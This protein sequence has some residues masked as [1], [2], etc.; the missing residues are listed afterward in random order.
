MRI[1]RSWSKC[2]LPVLVLL[3][4]SVSAQYPLRLAFAQEP[5]TL[6]KKAEIFEYDLRTNFVFEGQMPP[7]RRPPT[8]EH[9][10]VS[11][12]MPDNAYMTG[13]YAG[14]LAM[15]Y[16]VT[17]D[18]NVRKEAGQAL[19]ALHL[20]STVSGKKGLLARAAVRKD[21]PFLDDGKW[22]DSP[23]G[24]YRWRADVSSDQMDGV[25]YGFCLL[26]DLVADD[27]EKKII[28]PDVAD[29]VGSI[30]DNKLRIVDIDGTPT[31]WG[32]Y[33]PEYVRIREHMN[34][35]LLLQHVKVAHHV[36]GD[37][38]FDKEYLRIANDLGYA[39]LAV[40][41]RGNANPLI[42]DAV[43]YSDDV[44]LYLAYYPL[45]VLEKDVAL[46]DKYLASLRRTW[47][48]D[49]KFPGIKPLGCTYYAF[50]VHAFL[51][52]ASG[53]EAGINTLKW[54]P[55]DMKWNRDVIL[56][57]EKQFK[58]TFDPTPKSSEP[59]KGEV[60]PIDR[61]PK[62]WSA[63]VWDPYVAGDRKD[64][65]G[66]YYGGLDY[67]MAYWLGRYHGYLSPEM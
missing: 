56:A 10:F 39:D 35:L 28:A 33:Y 23:D 30:L 19:Q 21:M 5:L 13:I 61:R 26:F 34:A 17:K 45:L 3:C 57:Y 65:P 38:R 46:R 55:L 29:L 53:D 51:D 40:T 49:G 4:I 11:Y 2:A 59:G 27:A 60:V 7:K 24:T 52:D 18:E 12:N 22:Y 47:E 63:W 41:A 9:P 54:F 25:I 43:N 42:E 31:T 48:G 36:T 58:F 15:K 8:P 62:D 44:L 66:I 1:T 14:M 20:L 16:A 32:S 37:E 67:L 64:H 50:T 6:A